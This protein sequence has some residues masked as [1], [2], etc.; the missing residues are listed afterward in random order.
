M[1]AVGILVMILVSVNLSSIAM[2]TEKTISATSEDFNNLLTQVKTNKGSSNWDWFAHSVSISG[3]YALVGADRD[4]DMGSAYVFKYDGVSWVEEQKLI[5][6]DGEVDD[7]FGWSVSLDG[8][9]A[10]IG[11]PGNDVGGSAYVFKYN[12]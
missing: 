10:L 6:S 4:E 3:D 7:V 1:L 9:Y 2:N 5:A 11:A 12:G 8:D